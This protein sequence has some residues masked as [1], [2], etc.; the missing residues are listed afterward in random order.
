MKNL[1]ASCGPS[2]DSFPI[3]K[4]LSKASILSQGTYRN[5]CTTKFIQI[6]YYTSKFILIFSWRSAVS[7]YFS[8]R[9][10]AYI[11]KIFLVLPNSKNIHNIDILRLFYVTYRVFDF[12]F[13]LYLYSSSLCFEVSIKK[14]QC[15]R[16]YL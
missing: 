1:T 6:F 5:C 7:A 11:E 2:T 12:K 9:L 13:K 3:Q 4:N 8:N 16:R 10:I 15:T 14:Y